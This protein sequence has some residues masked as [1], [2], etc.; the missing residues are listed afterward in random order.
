MTKV[1]RVFQVSLRQGKA[2]AVPSIRTPRF[3]AFAPEVHNS[4]LKRIAFLLLL[5]AFASAPLVTAQVGYSA[6][7]KE[8]GM[9]LKCMCKGCDMTAGGCAHPGGS[10]SGPCDTAKSMLKEVDQHLAKGESEQQIIDAFVSEYGTIVYVEPPKKGFGLVA[11]LMP[12]FYFAIGLGLAIFI[13]RKWRNRQIAM[14]PAG[15]TLR[16]EILDRARA[17][18]AR[19]TED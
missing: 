15:P 12:I 19:E 2:P 1:E 13:V 10:F 5:G 9:H 14:A 17:Q 6:R 18:A 16:S 4:T 3:G 7:A 11:W 8:V